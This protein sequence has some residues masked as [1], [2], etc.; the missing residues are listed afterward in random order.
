M[1]YTTDICVENDSGEEEEYRVEIDLVSD[2][3]HGL[4]FDEIR[5]WGPQGELTQEAV[6]QLGLGQAAFEEAWETC[7][8]N[9]QVKPGIY[10]NRHTKRRIQVLGVCKVPGKFE[11][12]VVARGMGPKVA[13]GDDFEF[14][15]AP[16]CSFDEP[17]DSDEDGSDSLGNWILSDHR[18]PEGYAI[19]DCP[20]GCRFPYG[21]INDVT[22][23]ATC[24]G[25]YRVAE[26]R[27][28]RATSPLKEIDHL[29]QRVALLEKVI[30]DSI[31]GCSCKEQGVEINLQETRCESCETLTSAL[32]KGA[33]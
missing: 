28:R 20:N 12:L 30:S 5:A 33:K 4:D 9:G 32:T 22:R 10:V 27:G 21:K 18:A 25:C 13:A 6:D 26:A 16:P 15:L 24:L 11:W 3:D 1:K 2:G 17:D 23:K 19:V 31:A 14:F 8:V 29:Q 7:Y